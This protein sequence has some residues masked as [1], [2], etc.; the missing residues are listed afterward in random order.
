MQLIR[1]VA[2]F[3]RVR[4]SITGSMGLVPTMGYLHEGHL[5]LVRRARAENPVCVAW[6]FVNPTQFG[7]HEDLQ[8]YPR[9]EERDVALLKRE[10]V[11]ILFAPTADEIYPPGFDTHVAVGAVTERLE[12]AARPVHFRGV[13][14]V[15][16]KFFNIIQPKRAYFGQKDAQQ[17]VV[18]RRM[19][20]DLNLPVEIVVCPIV[21]EPDG[22]AMS[23]RNSY[24]T[25][26]Q[27]AAAPVLYRALAWARERWTEGERD[28]GVLRA[29]VRGIIDYE[30][31][32]QADYVSVAHP[33][34]LEELDRLDGEALVSLAVRFGSTRLIDNI[35]LGG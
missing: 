30:P 28:A 31:L 10:G 27:R 3:R 25:P 8:R 19:V 16:A 15:V 18:I 14:T 32:A 7:P 11:D 26:Q 9:D 6:I 13:A 33:E 21:R 24:L 5:S 12:G 34:T 23:S 2:E 4:S 29:L 17:V 35:V 22:L 1:T 20:A